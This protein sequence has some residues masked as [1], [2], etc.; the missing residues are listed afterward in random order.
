MQAV[1]NSLPNDVLDRVLRHPELRKRPILSLS[2]TAAVLALLFTWLVYAFPGTS[3]LLNPFAA[4]I[5]GN[6]SLIVIEPETGTVTSPMAVGND[7][8]ASGGKYIFTTVTDPSLLPAPPPPPNPP[9]PPPGNDP[10]IAVGGDVACPAGSAIT[11]TNCQ[12]QA[13]ANLISAMSPFPSAI[14]A[15][16]DLQYSDSTTA[17]IQGGYAPSWGISSLKNI[18]HPTAGNHEYHVGNAADYFTYWGSAAGTQGQGY[19]SYNVGT[20]HIIALNSNCSNMSSGQYPRG[21]L[22]SDLIDCNAQNTWL[23]QDLTAHPA[24]CT[25]AYW[26][27]S[28]FSSGSSGGPSTRL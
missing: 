20:W 21:T 11:S 24:T 26:H 19:Y 18:T 27:H 28:L 16:G 13:T 6:S 7:Q 17:E 22:T 9:P 8:A 2:S 4:N 1:I 3:L 10:I 23:Q 12:Q 14:L 15:P 5:V 25:L